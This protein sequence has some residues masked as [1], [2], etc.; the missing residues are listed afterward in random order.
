MNKKIINAMADL[1]EEELCEIVKEAIAAG[2][3]KLDII[4]DLQKGM[5]IV[6]E[7]FSTKEYFI[8]DLSLSAEMFEEC[9]KL[10]PEDDETDEAKYGTLV[11]GTVYSDLHDIGKNIVASIFK[12]NGFKVVDLG[13]DV[14]P[15]K[16][17]EAIREHDPKVVGM[18]CLLTT[19]FDPMKD[20]VEK[21]KETGL[22]KD[23]LILVGGSPIDEEIC[24]YAGA[25]DFVNDAQ[26]GVN[27]AVA[28]VQRP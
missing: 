15:E 23:R 12:C 6:G 11:L 14:R 5:G 8:A 4:D 18:S 21:I 3:D 9:Q 13:I 20:C 25:D 28:F 22:N 19:S 24:Q 10:F 17:I 7:R 2:E 1:E 26:A 27:K 16:F